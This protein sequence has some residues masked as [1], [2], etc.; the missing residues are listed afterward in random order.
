M[1]KLTVL[2]IALTMLLSFA[3]CNSE[4]SGGT[5]D[6]ALPKTTPANT[7]AVEYDMD[8]VKTTLP[9]ESSLKFVEPAAED[10]EYNYD[11]VLKGVII[12]KYKGK[13]AAIRIPT[14]LD[15]D[16]VVQ[17]ALG[18][19][20]QITHVEISDGITSISEDAFAYS[21]N[22]KNVK[23]PDSVTEIG[24]TAFF[25]CKTMK[26]IEIPN[27]VTEIGVGAFNSCVALENIEIPNS[28]T[29]IGTNA[30]RFCKALKSVKISDS[31]T[32]IAEN[33]FFDCESLE[34]ITIPGNVEYIGNHAFEDCASL[35][36]VTLPDGVI[37]GDS[38]FKNCTSLRSLTLS[39][40]VSRSGGSLFEGCSALTVTYKGNEYNYTNFKDLYEAIPEKEYTE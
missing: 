39:D 32:I 33:T 30:F 36:E 5:A 11:A 10:F 29:T 27:S 24:Q 4:K 26:S 19:R 28:V 35:K 21:S 22:L 25:L 40:N 34:S 3:A 7:G 8:G 17:F 23:I 9:A 15:G 16:P 14:E 6:A 20:P 12:T 1:K 18:G 31:I 37:L 2:A 13:A 38:A